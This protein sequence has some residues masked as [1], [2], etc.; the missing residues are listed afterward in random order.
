M[1]NLVSDNV[2][3]LYDLFQKIFHL[4]WL[5][6]LWKWRGI[7]ADENSGE[8]NHFLSFHP[9]KDE[10]DVEIE[11]YPDKDEIDVDN[12]GAQWWSAGDE[13]DVGDDGDEVDVDDDGDEVDERCTGSCNIGR[14][15]ISW[16]GIILVISWL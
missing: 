13:V 9:D 8:E 10:I 2:K 4:F 5:F 15:L 14:T 6:L 16:L 11:F 1:P 7:V 3:E 12:A